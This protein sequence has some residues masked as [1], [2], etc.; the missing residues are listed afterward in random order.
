[1]AGAMLKRVGTDITAVLNP[2]PFDAS[3]AY[4][5]PTCLDLEAVQWQEMGF[6]RRRFRGHILDTLLQD[7]LSKPQVR[8]HQCRFGQR[9]G[10]CVDGSD[11]GPQS[12]LE[13]SSNHAEV[14]LS[15]LMWY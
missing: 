5:R 14:C 10:R 9:Y 4:D 11:Y 15:W 7:C 8:D 6:E 12:S 2:A 13:C 1:M 3:A